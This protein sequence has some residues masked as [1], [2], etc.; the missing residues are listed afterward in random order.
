MVQDIIR[1]GSCEVRIASREIFVDGELRVLEP[2]PFDLLVYLIQHRHRTVSRDDLLERL[3]PD[4]TVTPSVVARAIMKAR[5]AIGDDGSRPRCIRTLHRHGYQFT[6][7]LV[8]NQVAASASAPRLPALNVSPT[9]PVPVSL[10]V[11]PFQNHTGS[12]DLGWVE[13]GLMSMVTQ[14]LGADPSITLPPVASL[15]QAVSLIDRDVPRQAKQMRLSQALGVGHI[16]EVSVGGNENAYWFDYAIFPSQ[17]CERLIASDLTTLAERLTEAIRVSIKGTVAGGLARIESVDD[18][19][20]HQAMVRALQALARQHWRKAGNLLSAA[21]DIT[22]NDLPVRVALLDALAGQG[23]EEALPLGWDLLELATRNGDTDLAIAVHLALGRA[24][25]ER[26]DDTTSEDHIKRALDLATEHGKAQEQFSARVLLSTLALRS[27][28]FDAAEALHTE[29]DRASPP[30]ERLT[31]VLNHKSNIAVLATR[32]GDVVQGMQLGR[33]VVAQ[34]RQ[35][36]L[37]QLFINSSLDLA[38]SCF[39]LGLVHEATEHAEAA[40]PVA[41]ECAEHARSAKLA[42]FLCLAYRCLRKPSRC[43]D[44]LALVDAT[45]DQR[46]TVRASMLAARAHHEAACGAHEAA[47]RLLRQSMDLR[48]RHDYSACIRH[49]AQW[50]VFTLAQAG[51]HDAAREACADFQAFPLPGKDRQSHVALELCRRVSNDFEEAPPNLDDDFSAIVDCAPVGFWRACATMNLAWQAIEREQL[52]TA[53]QLLQRLGPW[54]SELPMGRA[55]D[56]RYKFAKGMDA[57]AVGTHRRLA[58]S[59]DS[60]PVH[61]DQLGSMQETTVRDLSSRPFD[62]SPLRDGPTA[63]SALPALAFTVYKP[64]AGTCEPERVFDVLEI[65]QRFKTR[66]GNGGD[67]DGVFLSAVDEVIS[68]PCLPP[69]V[70]HAH[71]S[72]YATRAEMRC[73]APGNIGERDIGGHAA[74]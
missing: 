20:V 39:D 36:R 44:V 11:L 65:S 27:R 43:A 13:L 40:L 1:F 19:F 31:D 56:E 59:V 3:W 61:M 46:P 67:D 12:A 51:E 48:L 58:Q 47:A 18:P 57:Q 66:H 54:L 29:L 4:E 49:T 8:T 6:G 25:L 62:S 5:Q 55:L 37:D 72:I 64:E 21:R 28:D 42:E 50:L 9:A 45:L 71:Q 2:K 24:L 53:E 60:L 41:I 26:H 23:H 17:A 38:R 10:A 30:P 33:K 73:A 35:H 22:P 63:G 16:V 15:L 14:A 69:V 70:D 74:L 32:R 52:G 34:S 7:D 68:N